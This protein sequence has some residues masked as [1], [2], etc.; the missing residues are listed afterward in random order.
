MAGSAG[1]ALGAGLAL[2]LLVSLASPA[3]SE[4]ADRNIK[5]RRIS[6]ED[7]LSQAFVNNIVQ[8]RRG[9]M[10]FGTQEGLNLYD[11]HNFTVFA[12]SADDPNSVSHDLIKYLIEDRDGILWLGTDGGGLNRFDPVNRTFR[13]FEHDPAD[14]SSIGSNRVWALLEDQAGNF[15]VGTDDAGFYLFDRQTG[16]FTPFRHDPENPNS[17]VDDRVR[18][19]AEDQNGAIWIATEGGGLSRFDPVTG[20]FRR[21]E[22]DPDDPASLANN[23]VRHVMVDST[24]RVWAGTYEHGLDRLDLYGNGFVH[25]RWSESDSNS[26]A[27]DAVRVVFEGRDGTIWVGTDRGLSRYRKDSDDFANVVHDPTDRYSLS[28]DNVVSIY[29]DR[30]GVLWV[31]TFGGLNTWNTSTGYFIHYRQSEI[32][33]RGLSEA[34]VS[35]L[36]EDTSGDVWIGTVGGGLNRFNRSKGTFDYFRRDESDPSSI[37]DDRVMSLFVDSSETLWAG[38]FGAGLHRFDENTET[39]TQF[40]HDE[41]DPTSLSSNAITVITEDR[42]GSMWVGTYTGGLNRFDRRTGAAER[43]SHDPADP[44]SLS[45][46]RVLGVLEDSL[47]EL[48]VATYGAGLNV[49]DRETGSFT[50]I[51]HDPE[52]PESLSKDDLYSLFE[53]SQG[54]LWIGTQGGVMNS[55]SLADRK[56][57]RRRFRRI[58]TDNGLPSNTTN[59]FLE[60][61]GGDI[62]VSTISGLSRITPN[63]GSIK[64]FDTSHGLQGEFNYGAGLKTRDGK[65]FFGGIQGFNVFDAENIVRNDHIPPV[66]IT[67]VLKFDKSIRVEEELELSHSDAMLTIEFAALDYTAPERNRYLYK[68][69]G[70]DKNWV[71]YGGLRRATYTNLPPGSYQFQVKGSNNDGVWNETAASLSFHIGPPLWRTWPAYSVYALTLGLVIVMNARNQARKRHRAQELA[72]ANEALQ[73]EIEQ[74][75]LQGELLRMEKERAQTYLDVAEVIMLVVDKKGVVLLV[76]QKGAEVLGWPEEEIVGEEWLSFVRPD[77]RSMVEGFLADDSGG[78]FLEYSVLDSGGN[79]RIVAWHM[80]FLRD[81]DGEVRGTLSSGSDVTQMLRLR[82]AK[83]SAESASRAKSQFLA[84]MSHEIRTPMNGVLGMIELLSHSGLDDRQ[85]HFAD[86][87]HR[88]A[89]ALLDLLNDILDVSK[90]EAGK[91]ELETIDFAPRSLVEDT[92]IL[93]GEQARRKGLRLKREV[94]TSVPQSLPGDPVRLRQILSNLVGNAIKFTEQGEVTISVL[95]RPDGKSENCLRF[96]VRDTGVGLPSDSRDSIFEPFNQADGSTTRRFGGTGLG[97]TI[98]KQLVELMGGELGVESELGVGSVFWFTVPFDEE[99]KAGEKACDAPMVVPIPTHDSQALPIEKAS[100]LLVEDNPLNQEVVHGM[101]EHLHGQADIAVSGR[102]ALEMFKQNRYDLVLMDCQ[103]PNMDGYEATRRIRDVER[104]RAEDN[105]HGLRERVPVIAMTASALAGDRERCI[106]AGMDDYLGKP[107]TMDQLESFLSKW[108]TSVEDET[109]EAADVTGRGFPTSSQE[110]GE[111]VNP[112]GNA[113][114][115]EWSAEPLDQKCLNEIRK[116][117]ERGVTGLF[118]K[119]LTIYLESSPELIG[120]LRIAVE[121]QDSGHLHAAAHSLKSTS[122]SLGARYLASLCRELEIR[123]RK[124]EVESAEPVLDELVAEFERVTVALGKELHREAV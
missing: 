95:S 7:G 118:D 58:T 5:F 76:N 122:A 37:S 20:N 120:A 8:D 67:R 82:E 72:E 98:T 59:A 54:N 103:M 97:L 87:A 69:D 29:E 21:Y 40:V 73:L 111:S 84:N 75:K 25:Y 113:E 11:G 12:H 31:G 19:L 83:E 39:F 108:L 100:I 30:G 110:S 43:L 50:A 44:S 112:F 117:E 123:G 36:A 107:F 70:F 48:Y 13:L 9:F 124:G 63:N 45:S 56:A 55:W 22:N 64:N 46:N 102:Q 2:L 15:W 23:R 33:G 6:M 109:E 47:G 106:D 114:G 115:A 74:R 104:R 81:E 49:L 42:Q 35:A 27:G 41:Q 51:R 85:R 14:P 3:F 65:M 91:L 79:E 96:E 90:I 60:D 99:I 80:A 61:A 52:D 38:T 89:R 18:S 53:D 121:K 62:W 10:W 34:Y 93:F 116:L 71:D 78:D 94:N 4:L 26:V 105:G 77:Q 68:L 86:N 66:V 17:L 24:G 119:I 1:R 28:Q 57:G 32:E 101:L 16:K 92:M 88:A